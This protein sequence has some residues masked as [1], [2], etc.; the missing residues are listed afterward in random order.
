YSKSVEP[1]TRRLRVVEDNAIEPQGI[2]ELLGH[3]DIEIAT[4]T[5]GAEALEKL[6]D[7]PFDCCVLDLRL[8]D[9]TGFELL[10][11]VRGEPALSGIPIVVF[12]GKDLTREEEQ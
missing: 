12:T 6:L 2:V 7:R 8:P 4:A 9:M 5:T 1:R 11:R 3:D 10:E